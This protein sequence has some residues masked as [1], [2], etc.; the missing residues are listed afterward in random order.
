MEGVEFPDCLSDYVHKPNDENRKC[1]EDWLNQN[2]NIELAIMEIAALS[3]QSMGDARL[4]L[5]PSPG[6]KHFSKALMI[7]MARG[8]ISAQEGD[9]SRARAALA[10]ARN[11]VRHIDGIESPTLLEHVIAVGA[12]ISIHQTFLDR[13]YPALSDDSIELSLWRESL[14][15]GDLRDEL[16]RALTGENLRITNFLI[17]NALS[18]E[19]DQIVDAKMT[20]AE[21][22][23]LIETGFEM[24]ADA[25]AAAKTASHLDSIPNLYVEIGNKNGLSAESL[26][27][28]NEQMEIMQSVVAAIL[29]K[30][31]RL[32]MYD[33]ALAAA[34][35]ETMPPDPASGKQFQWDASTMTLNAPEGSTPQKPLSL[36]AKH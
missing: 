10:S 32:M 8:L 16:T 15:P 27:F 23:T 21:I 17:S 20:D 11:F 28:L 4:D 33:A 25:I 2:Q 5:L 31:T 18:G 36:P 9:E 35:G 1:A 26:A 29:K 24:K 12:R 34:I 19:F 30:E 7:M 14:A 13:I 3:K 22:R 6:M